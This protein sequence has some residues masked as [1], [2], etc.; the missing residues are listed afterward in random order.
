MWVNSAQR[1][2]CNGIIPPPQSSPSTPTGAP[3]GASARA[4]S[5]GSE[6]P[7]D[8]Q[9]FVSRLRRY[10]DSNLAKIFDGWVRLPIA[11]QLAQEKASGKS[12]AQVVSELTVT[13]DGARNSAAQARDGANKTAAGSPTSVDRHDAGTLPLD[14]ICSSGMNSQYTCAYI[15][16]SSTEALYDELIRIARCNWSQ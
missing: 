9:P 10:T 15:A 5:S 13:R 8:Q 12:L 1:W 4:G 6:C 14:F 7:R 3:A 2:V 16:T 11:Q